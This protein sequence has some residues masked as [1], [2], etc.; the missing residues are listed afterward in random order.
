MKHL[1]ITLQI[2]R[3]ELYITHDSTNDKCVKI[4]MLLIQL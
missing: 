4:E 3:E 2:G 1:Y